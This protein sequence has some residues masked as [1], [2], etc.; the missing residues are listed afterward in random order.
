MGVIG[1]FAFL[2]LIFI[3]LGGIIG[4]EEGIFLMVLIYMAILDILKTVSLMGL[5]TARGKELDEH[6]DEL[7]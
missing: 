2:L 6:D 4:K 7:S 5:F 3:V 1:G